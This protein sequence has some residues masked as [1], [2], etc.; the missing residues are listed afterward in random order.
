MTS[1]D[2]TIQLSYAQHRAID[3]LRQPHITAVM[4]GGARGGG[5]TVAGCYWMLLRAMELIKRYPIPVSPYPPL[6]VGLIARKR[7]T[8]CLATT[9]D[10]W[11][12]MMPPVYTI[13]EH[14][15][16][17][18]VMGRVRIRYGGLDNT[19][20]VNKFLGAE[21]ASVFID[22]AE[23]ITH[24]DYGMI[25]S[26][27]NRLTI[28]G[29]RIPG[30]ML[31][32]ANPPYSP[33]IRDE[34]LNP[35]KPPYN[36]FV[37]ARAFDNPFIDSAAYVQTLTDAWRHRPDIMRAYIYGDDID[38]TSASL[39][40]REQMSAVTDASK[41]PLR[42]SGRGIIAIDVAWG[43]ET[44]DDSVLAAYVGNRPVALEVV[45]GDTTVVAAKALQ[46]A[47]TYGIRTMVV[48][49]CG[50]GAGVYDTLKQGGYAMI[51]CN[52]AARCDE[53]PGPVAYLNTRAWIWHSVAQAI[54]ARAV[55]LPNDPYLLEELAAVTIDIR[56]GKITV[57]DKESIRSAL[58]RSPDRADAVAMA[59]AY[60][61]RASYTTHYTH[62][63]GQSSKYTYGARR[64]Y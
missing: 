53:P 6:C 3:L 12:R 60:L 34:F 47:K 61:P 57:T 30:K 59:I 1:M 29:E 50:I 33:V 32:T 58:G 31:L 55:V 15:A 10:T 41:V 17:I 16:M 23:E 63:T 37:P 20:A 38:V 43:K 46:V 11:R 62:S 35:R 42:Y 48:D 40:T 22:Q 18:V 45:R 24:E 54:Q 39:I 8:D 9:I 21:Y 7:A 19:E 51:P 26:T 44:S 13:M 28:H 2:V 14:K 36:E 5:K 49:V 4:Y 25:R 56:N 27:L 52:A 64:V